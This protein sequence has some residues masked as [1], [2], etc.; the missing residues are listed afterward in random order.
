MPT[1]KT[2][3]LYTYDELDEA[4]KE[5]ARSWFR[6]ATGSDMQYGE[7]VTDDF[8]SVCEALGIDIAT[9]T[10][11]RRPE[12]K[13]FWSGFWSQGD[14]ASFAGTWAAKPDAGDAIRAYAGEDVELHRI[15][16]A[17]AALSARFPN[18]RADITQSG[19]Y[20]HQ[21]TMSA[22]VEGIGE[23]DEDNDDLVGMA[24]V[25]DEATTLFR[26]LAGWLYR[27][28]EGAYESEND[29]DNVAENIRNND[30]TFLAS[31]KRED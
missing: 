20:V 25:E 14:G 27:T 13:V 30:Y 19:R 2:V 22:T 4:G 1:T 24:A 23:D 29:D 28:L 11:G 16:D 12:Y 10:R 26:D 18:A 31:G 5:V 15:G 6:E 17:L 9:D 21:Y 3:L 7:Q 8:L